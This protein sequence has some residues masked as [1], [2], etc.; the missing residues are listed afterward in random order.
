M[1]GCTFL[2]LIKH[3]FYII[4]FGLPG[5]CFFSQNVGKI[6]NFWKVAINFCDCVNP[7]YEYPLVFHAAKTV[8]Q[9]VVQSPPMYYVTVQLIWPVMLHQRLHLKENKNMQAQKLVSR[10]ASSARNFLWRNY[11]GDFR[12]VEFDLHVLHWKC[13][14]NERNKTRLTL[15]PNRGSLGVVWTYSGSVVVLSWDL[16][17]KNTQTSTQAH[18]CRVSHTDPSSLDTNTT[19]GRS[20]IKHTLLHKDINLTKTYL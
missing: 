3:I 14:K 4:F 10:W 6:W 16:T 5:I 18:A 17:H 2:P 13:P 11:V 15:A 20:R 9:C 19:R 12:L 8:R 7:L 1:L